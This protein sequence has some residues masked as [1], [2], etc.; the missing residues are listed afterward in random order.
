MNQRQPPVPPE[1][2]RITS[3]YQRLDRPEPGRHVDAAILAAS[4]R[5]V[6]AR[7]RLSGPFSGRWRVAL[8]IA[9]MFVM[10]IVVVPALWDVSGPA[11]DSDSLP[12][13]SAMTPAATS[14]DNAPAK[15]QAGTSELKA[16]GVDEHEATPSAARLR[17]KPETASSLST[18]P[19]REER[20][21]EQVLAPSPLPAQVGASQSQKATANE[22]DGIAAD[23]VAREATTRSTVID[24]NPQQQ[25][26]NIKALLDQ[27]RVDEARDAFKRFRS[28][29]PDY[30][31]VDELQRSLDIR[32]N[33]N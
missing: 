7:P 2:E 19:V 33:E 21:T 20:A 18:T 29:F 15:I 30:P 1:D 14:S 32:N 31:V 25:L 12:D 3:L 23:S 16:R 5:E 22:I 10:A 11:L 13:S 17:A 27:G 26:D 8:S 4:R 9:A 28:V 6:G 24:M